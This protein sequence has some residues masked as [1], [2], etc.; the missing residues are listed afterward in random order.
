MVGG[1][2]GPTIY[3]EYI[4]RRGDSPLSFTAP[5]H[6]DAWSSRDPRGDDSSTV[7]LYQQTTPARGRRSLVFASEEQNQLLWRVLTSRHC[8]WQ[9]LLT[10]VICSGVHVLFTWGELTNWND[11]YAVPVCLFRWS[12]PAGTPRPVG[13]LWQK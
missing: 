9:L 2:E 12:H 5:P 10:L 7:T 8:L 1:A 6:M 11:H 3:S 4:H 13:T